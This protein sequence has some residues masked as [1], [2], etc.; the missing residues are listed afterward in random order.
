MSLPRLDTLPPKTRSNERYE[1][2]TGL[3]EG[4]RTPVTIILFG[5][6]VSLL[7]FFA[8]LVGQSR[9]KEREFHNMA[10][11]R[12]AE[13]SS[14][15]M[16]LQD[17]AEELA[18][19][20]RTGLTPRAAM[21]IFGNTAD[22]NTSSQILDLG[23]LTPDGRNFSAVDPIGRRVARSLAGH[24][25]GSAAADTPFVLRLPRGE[26]GEVRFALILPVDTGIVAH[27]Y[28]VSDFD[29]LIRPMTAPADPAWYVVRFGDEAPLFALARNAAARAVVTPSMMGETTVVDTAPFSLR[30]TGAG[31][32]EPITVEIVPRRA[33]LLGVGILPWLVLTFSL[34]A[35]A[36]IGA[37]ALKDARRAEE[38]RREVDRKTAE[39]RRSHDIIAAKNEELARFAAHASHDLQA[40][41]RA[42]KGM[43]S[44][45][46][47]RKVDL[48]ARSQEML[49]RINRGA[50]RAQQLVQDLLSYTKADA[51]RVS[52]EPLQP[53][54][55]IEEIEELLGPAVE[56]TGGALNWDLGCTIEADRFLFTRALQNLVS[57]AIKYRRDV[58]LQVNVS[59]APHEAGSLI[60]VSDNGIGIE[61]RHFQRIFDVFER[62]HGADEY[63]GSGIGL[64][65]CKRVAELHG[66]RIWVESEPGNGSRFYLYLPQAVRNRQTA[67]DAGP[68][69]AVSN[70]R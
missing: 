60:C 24:Q 28:V 8:T 56:E 9:A 26:A 10:A 2:L 39:L 61:P 52:P 67:A 48:D 6:L 20:V 32:F 16:A 22:D 15:L 41:L 38:I 23:L 66:G 25:N 13:I 49:Q 7:L 14:G 17:E 70:D 29:T 4:Y 65:L 30:W 68:V 40:P 62:L 43:S 58:P 44:L 53:D 34:F 69:P 59:A 11:A 3:L 47:E 18:E 63:E 19:A 42:M 54:E 36:A 37:L 35:T 64:A 5:L 1:T 51:A 21:A 12:A 55:I 31:A 57:N 46:V 50:D 33:Y 27:A 45:L